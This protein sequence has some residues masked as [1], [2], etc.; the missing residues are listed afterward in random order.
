MIYVNRIQFSNAR[1]LRSNDDLDQPSNRLCQIHIGIVSYFQP[2]AI[3]KPTE[4]FIRN[5]LEELVSH[6]NP[7]QD[8]EQS[9]VRVVDV[10]VKDYSISPLPVHRQEGYGFATFATEVIAK[11]LIEFCRRC[12]GERYEKN[13]ISLDFTLSHRTNTNMAVNYPVHV[14]PFASVSSTMYQKNISPAHLPHDPIV[15]LS[16]PPSQYGDNP[17]GLQAQG[18]FPFPTQSLPYSN[19][20]TLANQQQAYPARYFM[21]ATD[22]NNSRMTGICHH[23]RPSNLS[24]STSSSDGFAFSSS[25]TLSTP[26]FG[27]NSY[28][29]TPK[30]SSIMLQGTMAGGNNPV[31]HSGNHHRCAA[32]MPQARDSFHLQH[33]YS[34]QALFPSS[35]HGERL[36]SQSAESVKRCEHESTDAIHSDHEPSLHYMQSTHFFHRDS[37]HSTFIYGESNDHNKYLYMHR[38]DSFPVVNP[39]AQPSIPNNTAH[40]KS[41]DSVGGN[42]QVFHHGNFLQQQISSLS[43][44]N[45]SYSLW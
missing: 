43:E 38:V 18:P 4:V 14:S 21:R 44:S 40:M 11:S 33:Q 24:M 32:T 27:S 5:M 22:Q 26:S 7:I 36:A 28:P 10:V 9:P 29:N 15:A 2:N 25:S 16:L 6:M 37:N 23:L 12:P 34:G 42:E 41:S 45:E 19:G 13:G 30:E 1:G 3:I 31:V 39:V 20:P 17:S 35:V 8:S